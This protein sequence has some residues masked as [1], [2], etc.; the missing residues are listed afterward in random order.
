V[1]WLAIGQAVSDLGGW[2]TSVVLVVLILV[3][4][5]RRWWVPGFL[6]AEM[7]AE[8]KLLRKSIVS[9]TGQLAR[10]RR[11]RRTDA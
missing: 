5:W 6:Y 2:T 4:L 8:V 7:D 9:L 10:E 3:G 11:R 1:D